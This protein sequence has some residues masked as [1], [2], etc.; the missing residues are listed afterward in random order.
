[1]NFEWNLFE[2]TKKDCLNLAKYVK[3]CGRLRVLRVRRSKMEDDRARQLISHILDHPSLETLGK[4][5]T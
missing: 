3:G 2:F 4:Q 1:M 5:Y